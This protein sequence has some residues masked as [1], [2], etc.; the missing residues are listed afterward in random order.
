[1]ATVKTVAI[2][3]NNDTHN[4][5]ATVQYTSGAVRN[6]GPCTWI[7][8][9]ETVREVVHS[10][11]FILMRERLGARVHGKWYKAL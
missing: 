3:R 5:E 9:P 7:Q 4:Y 8:M 2:F 6:Y 11:D 1:M 10:S